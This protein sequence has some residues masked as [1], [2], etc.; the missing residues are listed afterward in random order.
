[1]AV[2]LHL[3]VSEIWAFKQSCIRRLKAAEMQ[4]MRSLTGYSSLDHGRNGDI[5]EEL[6]VDRVEN[7]SDY[8][9]I[10]FNHVNM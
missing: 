2:P 4:F 9:K 8:K 3:H 1:L 5:L 6:K 7:K 10:W